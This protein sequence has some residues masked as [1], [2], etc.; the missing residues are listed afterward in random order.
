MTVSP[1]SLEPKYL[2]AWTTARPM[3]ARKRPFLETNLRANLLDAYPRGRTA[4][5]SRQSTFGLTRSRPA[6]LVARPESHGRMEF[7]AYA[8]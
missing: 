6:E 3:P 2:E 5:R 1:Q 8:R 7:E 4:R